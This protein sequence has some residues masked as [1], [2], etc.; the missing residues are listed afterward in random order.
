MSPPPKYNFAF[1]KVIFVQ[2]IILQEIQALNYFQSNDS[3][4]FPKEDK[5]ID[6]KNITNNTEI[7]D[8]R[9]L[10]WQ[11]QAET[12]K[13]GITNIGSKFRFEQKK[14][15]SCNTS[16]NVT[17]KPKKILPAPDT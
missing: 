6:I 11:E 9:N 1:I 8:V 2:F 5:E 7:N 17:Q 13:V 12:N 3:I 14:E 10:E 15:A 4:Y 16:Y